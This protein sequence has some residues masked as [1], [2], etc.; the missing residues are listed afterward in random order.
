LR[1]LRPKKEKMRENNWKRKWR[2]ERLVARDKEL[3]WHAC[4]WGM[5]MVML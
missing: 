4:I 5:A 3:E 1:T 2:R